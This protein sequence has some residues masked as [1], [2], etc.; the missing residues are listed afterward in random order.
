VT[1]HNIQSAVENE[2]AD[3]C[4]FGS[5]ETAGLL[6][7]KSGHLRKESRKGRWNKRYFVVHN[8][9]LNYYKRRSN[10][11]SGEKSQLSA[12]IDLREAETICILS[13][14]GKP[15][16]KFAIQTRMV[17]CPHDET[18]CLFLKA[19]SIEEAFEWVKVLN[20][21]RAYFSSRCLRPFETITG[22]D[23]AQDSNSAGSLESCA[24]SP[25]SFKAALNTCLSSVGSNESAESISFG[26]SEP[27]RNQAGTKSTAAAGF[28]AENQSSCAEDIQDSDDG[29]VTGEEDSLTDSSDKEVEFK[30]KDCFISSSI[31]RI[32]K[33]PRPYLQEKWTE[34]SIKK[35]M[36]RGPTYMQDSVKIP[37]TEPLFSLIAVD[38]YR[39][40]AR[41]D[42]IIAN[43]NTRLGLAQQ[44]GERHPF[45]FAIHIQV[46]GPPFYSFVAYFAAKLRTSKAIFGESSCDRANETSDSTDDGWR[47][48]PEQK[49]L[50]LRFFKG[51][52]DEIRNDRFKLV[53]RI[54]EGPFIVRRGVPSKP[55]IMGRKLTQRYFRG[56]NYLEL[57]IDVSSSIVAWKITQMSVGYA[58][59]LTVDLAAL[60]QG[61][62]AE[63]LPEL[64]IGIVRCISV[65]MSAAIDLD[66]EK[67]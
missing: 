61:N 22:N 34:P 5:D 43:R 54:V 3:A 2:D 37:A 7:S 60:L 42:H 32:Q 26:E 66:E 29:F 52:D 15:T 36:I 38:L 6:P 12:S 14:Y 13:R 50:A 62:Q 45:I 51:E 53:P 4:L 58:K 17:G 9:Y 55:A 46:P 35:L 23:L 47:I 63:E 64:V 18:E 1:K 20:E 19:Y 65:D 16:K 59:L 39:T 44:R 56:D 10:F 11:K 57:C 27:E 49:A 41:Y 24:S 28:W 40:K 8:A 67:P 48:T 30:Q 21:R 25:A 31:S 33:F